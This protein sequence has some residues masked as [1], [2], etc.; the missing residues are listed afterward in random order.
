M[1]SSISTKSV[2][3]IAAATV[4]GGV[5]AYAAYF[6]Y[7]RRH[8]VKFRKQLRKEK[9]KLERSTPKVSATAGSSR[10]VE[11]ITAAL[12]LIQN[13][14]LPATPEEKEQYFMDNVQMGEQL[15]SQGPMFE[16]PAALSFFRALR[17][18]P[19]PVELIMIYQKTVPENVFKIV[20]EMTSLDVSE[21]PTAAA[22]APAAPA[23]PPEQP[24]IVVE[25]SKKDAG[26]D[27]ED[28]AS[29]ATRS[30]PPSETSSQEW[31][32]LT[33]T[34]STAEL[35]KARAEGY[36]DQ[37]PDPSYN[38]SVEP[39]AVI[40]GQGGTSNTPVKKNVLKAKKDFAAG[41][42]IYKETPVVAV[43]DS[44]LEAS[45]RDPT[46][47][48]YTCFRHI[49]TPAEP[50][51]PE[52]P[53]ALGSVYC[54]TECRDAA[55][56]D[57]HMLLFGSELTGI[58]QSLN[59]SAPDAAK[60]EAR[61]AAQEKLAKY[62]QEH[63]KSGILLVARFLARMVAEETKKLATAGGGLSASQEYSLY[64]HV[65]R[66]RYLEF[67]EDQWSE[68]KDLLSEVLK[69]S[70]DG[71]EE[72]LKDERYGLL[73][74]KMAYNGVGVSF[75]SGRDGKPEPTQRPEDREWTRT[76]VGTDRQVGSGLYLI[77]SYMSHSCD[78]SVRPTF[79]EGTN[80]LHL[81][82]AK[83]IKAGDELTMPYVRLD[84]AEDQDV[85]TA[86]R[87]RRQALARGWR[88][89]CNCERCVKEAPVATAEAAEPPKDDV[90]VEGEGA[91]AEPTVAR[92]ES[93]ADGP[94]YRVGA[95]KGSSEDDVE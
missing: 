7:K 42:T 77:S 56:N 22:A 34:G 55:A 13:E 17:V 59:V 88:F 82:A 58:L 68:Q 18:Y 91:K 75:G 83:D 73:L 57:H 5:I 37:F 32:T 40:G 64:D 71:L 62:F 9:K 95:P 12:R 84:A 46:A 31:D 39:V 50:V 6:D 28:D 60:Q 67:S 43:L 65:E 78:P 47:S 53:D 63:G 61:K 15:C 54:S 35:V 38:V 14:P 24:S 92:F 52:S 20:M 86:R 30:G 49:E 25:P 23:P 1:S 19:S 81:V 10:S 79:P 27:D 66:L 2:L 21:P 44:D 51:K 85:S 80:E 45:L 48:Y 69:L 87:N 41:E 29:K 70:A 90:Q 93:G 3:T 89:A 76:D 36:Y 33:D 11:E 8:D 72:F 94:E 74:G 26:S 16:I 4:V